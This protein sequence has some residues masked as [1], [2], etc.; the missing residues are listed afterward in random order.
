VNPDLTSYVTE[1]A[2]NGIYV[3]IAEEEAKIRTNPAAQVTS[4][5]KR[6]FGSQPK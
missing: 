5:L 6:V 1:R 2:L 4:L 3:T